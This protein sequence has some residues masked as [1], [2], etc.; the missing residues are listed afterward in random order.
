V[1]KGN[2]ERKNKKEEKKKKENKARKPRNQKKTAWYG[3]KRC[4]NG[5]LTQPG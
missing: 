4:S 5:G 2:I 1:K 3:E